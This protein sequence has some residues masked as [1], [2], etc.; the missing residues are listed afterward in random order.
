MTT[1]IDS[2]D[3]SLPSRGGYCAACGAGL[4]VG[5]HFCHRCGTPFGQGDPLEH[6]TRPVPKPSMPVLVP[7]ALAAL[8]LVVIVAVLAGREGGA[9]SSRTTDRAPDGTTGPPAAAPFATGAGGAPPDI[10]SMT[11]SERAARLYVRVMEYAEAGQ[12]D[13]VATFAPMVLAAHQMI[14]QPTVDERYHF[15]RVAEVVGSEAIT[16]AQADTILQA[17]PRSLLGLLLAAR[18]AR[19]AGDETSAR[20]FDRT[21][22]SLAEAEL[23]TRNADYENHRAEIDRAVA[24]ARRPD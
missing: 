21:L 17:N 12:V 16:K 11:P 8:S 10:G 14:E 6:V 7:W 5:A 4:V 2:G 1:P 18:A 22:L 19:S 23:A 15:G 9:G 24:E 20:A 13:S 3:A